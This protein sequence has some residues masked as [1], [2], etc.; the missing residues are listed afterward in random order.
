MTELGLTRAQ[1][2]VIFAMSASAILSNASITPVL[3]DIRD[4]FGLS[5]SGAVFILMSAHAPGLFM[6]SV[7]GVAA[8][9]YGRRT[10]IVP[11]LV[12][13]GVGGLLA[14][15]AP[16]F[17]LL[18]A[19]RLLQGLGSAA[20]VNLAVVIIG[21]NYTGVER[22]KILGRNSMGITAGIALVPAAGGLLGAAFGWRGPFVL[23]ALP[24]L[25]AMGAARVLPND[26][27]E[28]TSS[29]RAQLSTARGQ[30]RRP[31]VK[32]LLLI[33]FMG[34]VM[35]FGVSVTALSLHLDQQYDAGPELR[36]LIIASPAVSSVCMA[37]LLGRVA[38]R[39]STG[40]LTA[41]G[42]AIYATLT[43][44]CG[45]APTLLLA[46]LPFFFIGFG[47]VLI[48]VPLQGH[49]TALAPPEQRGAVV[50]AWAT[51]VRL[52]QLSAPLAAAVILKFADTRVLMCVFGAWAALICAIVLARKP[53]LDG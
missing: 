49:T 15:A 38:R 5:D 48:T 53:L 28:I 50:A 52:G 1:Q 39:F 40:F 32:F 30:I 36:G 6:A 9:R 26:R 19:A 8:D 47:E 35:F 22:T 37:L 14:M 2:A 3:P 13:F 11:C 16:N 25:V 12:T 20:F 18:I 41:C 34:F 44:A 33:A 43:T 42:F 10:V 46:A 45:L 29:F 4:H 31:E 27:P 24:L 17:P 7:I 21:D 23:T 51:A